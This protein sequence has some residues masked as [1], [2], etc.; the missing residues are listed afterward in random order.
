MFEHAQLVAGRHGSDF[1][2]IQPPF[3]ENPEHFLLAPLLRDQQHAFLRFAE[4][5]LVGTH[6]GLALWHAI[7][8][9]L[10]P[11]SA[12]SAHFAG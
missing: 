5:D 7:E 10:N 1:N 9:N 8:F 11:H 2:R 4:H 12:A 3:L 6:A